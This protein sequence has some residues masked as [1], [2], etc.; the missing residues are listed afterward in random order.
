MS[1]SLQ[2]R[3]T[4]LLE[5]RCPLHG[6]LMTPLVIGQAYVRCPKS[7]CGVVAEKAKKGVVL[8]E[9]GLHLLAPAT[10]E[11]RLTYRGYTLV[12]RLA[13]DGAHP[14]PFGEFAV[15]DGK[16][17][18]QGSLR[19]YTRS[20]PGRDRLPATLFVGGYVL[21]K[22]RIDGGQGFALPFEDMVLEDVV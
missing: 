11:E 5:G 9:A 20:N 6:L 22:Q 21:V 1:L 4:R 8:T 3:I 16:G 12:F 17:M 18:Y 2:T 14:G 15:W 19:V 7:G 10:R 13:A